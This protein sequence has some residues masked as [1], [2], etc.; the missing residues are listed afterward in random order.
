MFD[1]LQSWFARKLMRAVDVYIEGIP[2]MWSNLVWLVIAVSTALVI[3][4]LVVGWRKSSARKIAGLSGS[5][6]NDLFAIF[7]NLSGIGNY[8]AILMSFGVLYVAI[9]ALRQLLGPDPLLS[10]DNIWVA[11]I[12]FVL[13]ADLVMYWFHRAA[14]RWSALW[15]VHAYHHSASEMTTISGSREHPLFFPLAAFWLLLPT[16]LIGRHPEAGWVFAML[17]AT[18]V[19][20]LLIHSNITSDWGWFGRWVLV[21]PAMHRVHHGQGQEFHNTNF[22]SL[23][24]IWDRLFGT[25]KDPAGTQVDAVKIG[26][27]DIPGDV[28]P[29]TYLMNT[30]VR[31]LRTVLR[32]LRAMAGRL[33]PSSSA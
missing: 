14:H 6:R 31:F 2:S 22:G 28:S 18:R 1:D 10:I 33:L 19:H 29:W 12:A 21:P 4:L 8:V 11:T 9:K 3:E 32:P 27:A 20:G 24:T 15:D 30:Y 26:L 13:L 25:W 23:L 16:V 17:F 5:I 7:M